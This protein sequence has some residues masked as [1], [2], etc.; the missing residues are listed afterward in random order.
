ME[1]SA[2]DRVWNRA[3]DYDFQP[4]RN[5][6]RLL[7]AAIVFDGLTANGGLTL[8]LDTSRH[9]EALEAVTALHRFGLARAARV[10]ERAL[11]V[12]DEQ[13]REKMTDEYYEAAASLD[14]AFARY[15]AEHPDEF[16]PPPE[17][18]P[19]RTARA[20]RG[21]P[22]TRARELVDVVLRALRRA[23]DGRGGITR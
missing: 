5:G 11:A 14:A 13:A 19:Q 16:D 2:A 12:N 20:S 18:S 10:V 6:D 23:R 3:C 4:R 17:P 9:N 15:Y 7:K 21:Q 22:A 8:S 1:L